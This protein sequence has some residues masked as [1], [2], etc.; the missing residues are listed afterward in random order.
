MNNNLSRMVW[1]F[2]CSWTYLT[3]QSPPVEQENVELHAV[4]G[5][6][7]F[8]QQRGELFRELLPVLLPHLVLE[9]MQDLNQKKAVLHLA[10]LNKYLHLI[11]VCSLRWWSNLLCLRNI[12]IA[13]W[14]LHVQPNITRLVLDKLLY[15]GFPHSSVTNHPHYDIR[16]RMSDRW[17]SQWGGTAVNSRN[18]DSPMRLGTQDKFS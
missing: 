9:T 8:L 1:L 13:K 2:G 3:G 18:I 11:Q 12:I 6:K 10:W 14:V 7:S 17:S 15:T 4:T 16:F 5:R